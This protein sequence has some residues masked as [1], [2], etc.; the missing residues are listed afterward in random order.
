MNLGHGLKIAALENS[1]VVQAIELHGNPFC[2]GVQW[3]PEF[4][5]MHPEQLKRH[6][7][8]LRVSGPSKWW[9]SGGKH[10]HHHYGKLQGNR[11]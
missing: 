8:T 6:A 4:L 10:E 9:K 1:G 11:S 2:L 7:N 3:Q 5:P